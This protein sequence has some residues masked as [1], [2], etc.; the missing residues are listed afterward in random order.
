MTAGRG[1]PMA[2]LSPES[3]RRDVEQE[4]CSSRRKSLRAPHMGN[5]PR[6]V[7][8]KRP[9]TG[10]LL[11][12][13]AGKV[14]PMPTQPPTHELSSTHELAL[15]LAVRMPERASPAPAAARLRRPPEEGL[16]DEGEAMP[17]P[18][19]PPHAEAQPARASGNKQPQDTI[20]GCRLLAEGDMAR[21]RDTDTDQSRRK[22]EHSAAT[23]TRRGDMLEDLAGRRVRNLAAKESDPN[24]P[25]G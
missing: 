10:S 12:L 4:F 6:L 8:R 7:F 2:A 11:L 23:W 18:P 19:E 14:G 20:A 15:G 13:L 5:V 9:V 22:F 3:P 25:G 16:E 1:R 21:A 17:S 24:H